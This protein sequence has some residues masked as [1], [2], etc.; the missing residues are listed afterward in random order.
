MKR[1]IAFVVVLGI[2]GF[3]SCSKQSGTSAIAVICTIGSVSV[4]TQSGEKTLS[5]G[6]TLSA[7]DEIV[8]GAGSLADI[9]FG[10]ESV[11]RVFQSTR[12][13][14]DSSV[15]GK[16]ESVNALSMGSGK[17]F[18]ASSKLSKNSSF[19]IKTNTAVAAVR[20]TS[21]MISSDGKTSNVSVLSGKI[22]VNP[23]VNGAE[24][25]KGS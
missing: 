13:K 8:A 17:L 6:D 11:V 18:V 7:G 12:F 22:K 16:N 10:S 20:G 24:Q 14:I 23:V 1:T 5:V 15:I 9:Q 2:M 3:V 19:K 25:E 4:V 21:Y